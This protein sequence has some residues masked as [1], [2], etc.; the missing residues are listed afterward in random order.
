LNTG[1]PDWKVD[2]EQRKKR[3]HSAMPVWWCNAVGIPLKSGNPI[4]YT[5][6][7]QLQYWSTSATDVWHGMATHVQARTQVTARRSGTWH[8]SCKT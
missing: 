8:S 7:A 6:H 5:T 3:R 1:V 4:F 2:G